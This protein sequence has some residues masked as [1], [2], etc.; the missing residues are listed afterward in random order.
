MKRHRDEL[1]MR[2]NGNE[3]R[4]K[5]PK[6]DFNN[7][8]LNEIGRD[9]TDLAI[10]KFS[11]TINEF[12]G[13]DVLFV[14]CDEYY[15]P[16]PYDQDHIQIISIGGQ[17]Y[18]GTYSSQERKISLYSSKKSPGQ[19]ITMEQTRILD[20]LYPGYKYDFIE[21]AN[22]ERDHCISSSALSYILMI[23]EEKD[24][25]KFLKYSTHKTNQTLKYMETVNNFK[26]LS[27]E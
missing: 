13:Y 23:M 27:L 3:N 25:N 14:N 9:L 17:Y 21:P 16:F 22:I 1:Y 8:L 20:R 4:S 12:V 11:S 6:T 10:I 5:R 18:A 2:K 19:G 15:Q 7:Q 24:P 26:C